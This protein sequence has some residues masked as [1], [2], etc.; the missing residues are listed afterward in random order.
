[1]R[2]AKLMNFQSGNIQYYTCV[3]IFIWFEILS[4][5]KFRAVKASLQSFDCF[6]NFP[7]KHKS[8][9]RD[10]KIHPNTRDSCVTP[11][12]VIPKTFKGNLPYYFLIKFYKAF[13]S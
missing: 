7:E 13:T 6:G 12:H 5:L 11:F 4:G 9:L 10:K 8:S 3:Y 1:M 2:K